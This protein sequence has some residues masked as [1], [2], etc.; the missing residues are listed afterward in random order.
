MESC[1]LYNGC[2]PTAL[3]LSRQTLSQEANTGDLPF[4]DWNRSDE[5]VYSESNGLDY[6][7]VEQRTKIQTSWP[8]V[9]L[10]LERSIHNIAANQSRDEEQTSLV[11][12]SPF[13]SF[14]SLKETATLPLLPIQSPA[15][16]TSPEESLKSS[17]TSTPA[18]VRLTQRDYNDDTTS[19][20]PSKPLLS[21]IRFSPPPESKVQDLASSGP[22]PKGNG[23]STYVFYPPRNPA[24]ITSQASDSHRNIPRRQLF[25]GEP[26]RTPKPKSL[27]RTTGSI[28]LR[29][30]AG[31]KTDE[32]NGDSWLE[33]S[34]KTSITGPWF[35]EPARPKP[36][37]WLDLV[38]EGEII[39]EAVRVH[40]Y[41]I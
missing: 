13:N 20:D 14:K 37:L 38:D 1:F 33:G 23:P 2:N 18:D 32:D 15:K 17:P 16:V 22:S 29:H 28:E 12:T 4:E 36:C 31:W 34:S 27:H 5:R 25:Y 19:I 10:P 11:P 3:C 39:G 7:L 40:L 26:M 30:R 8:L 6:T 21:P 35:S 41:P 24:D 9:P